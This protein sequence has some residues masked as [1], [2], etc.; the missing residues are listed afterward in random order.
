M[1]L[2]QYYDDLSKVKQADFKAKWQEATKKSRNTFYQ[3]LKNAT[4]YDIRLF[5]KAT[6]IEP[7]EI[8]KGAP[9]QLDIFSS[10]KSKYRKAI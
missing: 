4:E 7:T 2:R 10:T 8:H 9:A 3:M 5:A 1:T 6:G